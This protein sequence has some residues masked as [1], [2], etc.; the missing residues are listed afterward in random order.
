M[1]NKIIKWG[2]LALSAIGLLF[3]VWGLRDSSPL[4]LAY[5]YMQMGSFFFAGGFIVYL[6][7]VVAER[8]RTVSHILT[9]IDTTMSMQQAV[10][11]VMAAPI[12]VETPRVD[13]QKEAIRVSPFTLPSFLPDFD[14]AAKEPAKPRVYAP[15]VTPKVD[16]FEEP[17]FIEQAKEPAKADHFEL[18]TPVEPVVAVAPLE[19]VKESNERLSQ[20]ARDFPELDAIL[21]RNKEPESAPEPVVAPPVSII[22]EGVISGIAF[23]LFS[24]GTIEADF[25][26]GRHRFAGINEF[27]SF[28]ENK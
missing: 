24:D 4:S 28:V 23:R 14:D 11:Q 18:P 22:R 21:N 10:P 25:A 15:P 20:I 13:V 27:R 17:P 3:I 26:D 5:A 1:L 8:L 9:D 12:E 16:Y 19:R 2:G 7:G 6:L